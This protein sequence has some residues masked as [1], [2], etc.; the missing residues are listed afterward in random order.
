MKFFESKDNPGLTKSYDCKSIVIGF[1]LME[2]SGSRGEQHISCTY[3]DH[4]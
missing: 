4:F 2:D 1:T 3:I